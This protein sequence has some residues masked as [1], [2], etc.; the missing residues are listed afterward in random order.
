MKI[1]YKTENLLKLRGYSTKTIKSYL[2]YI[3]E[4]LKFAEKHNITNKNLAIEKFLLAKQAKGNSP[5]TINLALSAINF[6]YQEVLKS[7]EKINFK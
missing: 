2:F 4:Y 1:L 6:L 3:T 5:Q 7:K